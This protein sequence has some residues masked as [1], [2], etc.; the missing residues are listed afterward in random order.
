MADSATRGCTRD[1]GLLVPRESAC[2]NRHGPRRPRQRQVRCYKLP[3]RQQAILSN[4][5]WDIIPLLVP[6]YISMNFNAAPINAA[7]S[8]LISPKLLRRSAMLRKRVKSVG[9][10]SVS[11]R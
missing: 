5:I 10:P 9:K 7:C 6:Y 2:R 3:L 1:E 11:T 8:L 4:D